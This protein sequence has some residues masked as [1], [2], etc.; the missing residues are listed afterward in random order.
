VIR[1]AAGWNVA[2]VTLVAVAGLVL[3]ACGLAG[4]DEPRE[5]SADRLPAGLVAPADTTTTVGAASDAPVTVWMIRD[6]GIVP[7]RRRVA[8]PVELSAVAGALLAG[9]SPDDQPGVRSAWTSP[10]LVER[11][12]VVAGAAAVELASAFA[13]LPASEQLLAV[14]QMVYTL[15]GQPGIGQV[16][17]LRA[18]EVVSVPGADG[19]TLTGP[20]SRDD[21]SSL[22]LP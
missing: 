5:I 4:E 14:A 15:T 19:S 6:A 17:F 21:Y 18:G 16:R 2:G 22:V 9:I 20:V 8:E 12:D 1:P 11:V 3:A 13:D 7:V 10:D